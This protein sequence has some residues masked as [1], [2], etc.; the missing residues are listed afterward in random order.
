MYRRLSMDNKKQSIAKT[1]GFF[2]TYNEWETE[3]DSSKVV[4]LI[5]E[6]EGK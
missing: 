4:N 2:N 6:I 1:D 3:N 5:L